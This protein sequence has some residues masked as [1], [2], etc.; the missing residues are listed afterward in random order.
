MSAPSTRP[1]LLLSALASALVAAFVLVPGPV[2]SIGSTG[3]LA[4]PDRL[5]AGVREAYAA[6]WQS[7]RR[8]FPSSLDA[9]V[10]FWFRYHVTKAVIAACALTVLVLLGVLVWQAFLRADRRWARVGAA[11]AGVVVTVL[12]FAALAAAMANVQGAVAPFASLLPMTTDSPADARL[13]ATLDSARQALGEDARGGVPPALDATISDFARYHAALAVIAAVVAV[14]SIAIGVAFLRT[15]YARRSAD[16]RTKRLVR[17]FGV[18]FLALSLV[19]IVIAVANTGTAADP[20]PALL[21][22]FEG[23]W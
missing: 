12:G 14:G 3:D 9:V 21:A 23:G 19:M 4:D 1:L 15:R 8:S 11:I 5:R 22:F 13:A 17:S 16:R 10:D 6:Y 20:K 2:A 7:G 18:L